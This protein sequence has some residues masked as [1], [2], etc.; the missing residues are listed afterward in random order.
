MTIFGWDMSHYDAPSIG[1]A[2]AEGISF[3]THKDGGDAPDDEIAAWWS[4]VKPHRGQL[5]LGAYWI[6]LPGNPVG[7]AD[8]FLARLDSQCP[9]WRD[10]PFILQADCEK[11]NNDPSTVPNLH[12]IQAFCD[13]LVAK[14]PKLTPIVYAPYWV[15][16][17]KLRGLTY[18]LWASDYVGGS[19]SFISLY[20]GDVSARWAA[21]SGQTPAILQYTSSAVI[22][23]QTT[24]DANA[25]RGTLAELV[26]LVAP[27]WSDNMTKQDVL[28]ALNEWAAAGVQTDGTPDS[29][30]GRRALN[31]GIP[32]GLKPADHAHGLDHQRT[33]AWQAITDIGAAVATLVN[34]PQVDVP[35]L[36]AAIVALLP[37]VTGGITPEQVEQ[38]V[39]NVLH[40]A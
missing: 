37:P 39:R 28:D 24:S 16:T 27:G 8:A 12:E 20:P 34:R 26:T 30:I 5:L 40:G 33:D 17:N 15:Y 10:G 3:V 14:M 6:L 18:P 23:G 11:W 36:A 1:N 38:A 35:A 4:G 32:N 21:Y 19:G 13:R 25:F 31:Q 22:G 2:I 29:V 7:R 9:G